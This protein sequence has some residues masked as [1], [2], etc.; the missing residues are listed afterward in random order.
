ML[1]RAPALES[2]MRVMVSHLPNALDS[3]KVETIQ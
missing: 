1:V 3:L 2:G